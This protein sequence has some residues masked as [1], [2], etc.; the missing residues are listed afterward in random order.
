M[1]QPRGWIGV[2]ARV[3]LPSRKWTV[4]VEKP[5]AVSAGIVM[6]YLGIFLLICA[7]VA[8]FIFVASRQIAELKHAQEKRRRMLL[9]RLPLDEEQW[10]KTYLPTGLN[11]MTPLIEICRSLGSHLGVDWTQLRPDD[12]FSGTLSVEPC[13]LADKEMLGFEVAF[14]DWT[15]TWRLTNLKGVMPDAFGEFLAQVTKLRDF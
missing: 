12:T 5:A 13:S 2:N 3:V 10:L 1:R 14:E 9:Q 4:P 6:L 7:A 8:T 15:G 11:H